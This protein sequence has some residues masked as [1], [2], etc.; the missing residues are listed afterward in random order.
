[1]ARMETGRKEEKKGNKLRKE[2]AVRKIVRRG[3]QKKHRKSR[4]RGR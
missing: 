2:E 3:K 1:M 4:K